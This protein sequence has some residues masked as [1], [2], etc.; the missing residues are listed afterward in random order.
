MFI[1]VPASS[2]RPTCVGRIAPKLAAALVL[3]SST[4][5]RTLLLAASRSYC[6]NVTAPR[7]RRAAGRHDDAPPTAL[8]PRIMKA[9]TTT[10]GLMM[11]YPLP[12]PFPTLAALSKLR[13]PS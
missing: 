6:G 5:G 11:K 7:R 4:S 9:S 1:V 2:N 8:S 3:T 10:C 12:S 13:G